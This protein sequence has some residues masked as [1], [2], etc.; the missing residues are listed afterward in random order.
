MEGQTSKVYVLVRPGLAEFLRETSELYELVLYTAS[1]PKYANP[2]IDKI[3]AGNVITH[4]LFREHCEIAKGRFVKNLSRLGRSLRDIIMVD[5]TPLSY[6]L[7]P[8]NGIPV[9]TWV[10]SRSDTQLKDLLPLLQLLAKVPDVRVAISKIVRKGMIDYKNS[11]QI[12]KEMLIKSEIKAKSAKESLD[13]ECF[14]K[15]VLKEAKNEAYLRNCK[16]NAKLSSNAVKTCCPKARSRTNIKKILSKSFSHDYNVLEA[17]EDSECEIKCSKDSQA[18]Y[19]ASPLEKLD[20]SPKRKPLGDE[21]YKVPDRLAP[22][23]NSKPPPELLPNFEIS[24]PLKLSKTKKESSLAYKPLFARHAKTDSYKNIGVQY[25]PAYYETPIK[26]IPSSEIYITPDKSIRYE[27]K[28]YGG[29]RKSLQLE[30]DPSTKA[31]IDEYSATKSSKEGRSHTA[32][33]NSTYPSPANGYAP[34]KELHYPDRNASKGFYTTQEYRPSENH[35][36]RSKT[37][38]YCGNMGAYSQRGYYNYT[39]FAQE[40]KINM[41]TKG[42]ISTPAL[43]PYVKNH[44]WGV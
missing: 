4:R 14:N 35:F 24:N 8:H 19:C 21:P 6:S 30:F 1:I 26:S 17:D 13:K 33:F 9:N 34:S 41:A 2:I 27:I 12:L 42:R 7:Q 5:N 20:D 37:D 39:P 11:L 3:D 16:S 28:K 10:S 36:L 38:N 44:R 31:L 43:Q 15:P 22:S 18:S 25:K 40:T 23:S 32:V 29:G